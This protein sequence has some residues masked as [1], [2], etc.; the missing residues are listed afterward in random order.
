MKTHIN[1]KNIV[2]L[3]LIASFAACKKSALNTFSAERNLYFEVRDKV[4]PFVTPD[5]TINTDSVRLS[6]AF[7]ADDQ[8]EA[9]LKIP[10]KLAGLQLDQPRPYRLTVDASSS[11]LVEGKDYEWL[12]D[13]VF[14][15]SK[16]VDTLRIKVRRNGL[17]QAKSLRLVFRL[18]DNEY[19][20]TNIQ[21]GKDKFRSAQVRCYINDIMA[22][23]SGYVSTAS[24]RG[25]DYY[26]GPFSKKKLQIL[27]QIVNGFGVEWSDMD[28]YSYLVIYADF[29]GPELYYYLLGQKDAGNTIY[30]ADGT[31]MTAGIAFQ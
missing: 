24:S 28:T 21:A 3:F 12:S 16:S 13:F 17:M 10:I 7:L 27:T 1:L 4:D 19:F 20:G 30:E 8:Q 22:P 26:Y 25:A 14:P 11:D 2:F 15:A 23:P 5:P 31:E 9:E 6:F 29:L 18:Q